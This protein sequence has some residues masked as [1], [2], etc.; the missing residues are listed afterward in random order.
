MRVQLFSIGAC[1]LSAP[2]NELARSGRVEDS[3]RTKGIGGPAFYTLDEAIQIIRFMRGE[4]TIPPLFRDLLALHQNEDWRPLSACFDTA[5]AVLIEV[6]SPVG[7]MYSRY[8]LCRARLAERILTPLRAGGGNVAQAAI[9]WYWQGLMAGNTKVLAESAQTLV[10]AVR[11]DMPNPDLQ[12]AVLVDTRPYRRDVA[13]LVEGLAMVRDAF[14][15]PIGVI[16]YTHQYMPDG[17]PLPWPLDFVEQTLA[18]AKQL[19]LPVFKPSE[20]V[21]Q[22]GA[23][24][25]LMPDRMHYQPEFTSALADQMWEFVKDIADLPSGTATASQTNR[26]ANS[27]ALETSA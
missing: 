20:F 25:A 17:R 10:R 4:L 13:G 3:W 8:A 5:Q 1:L 15:A 6:N 9:D 27:G 16:T 23:K 21:A 2:V 11:D 18:A 7:I 22:Y 24:R 19:N 14:R 26:A 12:R